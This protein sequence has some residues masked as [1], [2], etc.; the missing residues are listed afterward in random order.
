MSQDNPFP[1]TDLDRH[2]IWEIVVRRDTNFFLSGDWSLVEDD[3]LADGFI[4]IDAHASPDPDRWTIGFRSLADYR[5]AAI[6]GRLKPEDFA[7]DLRT[8]WLRCQSLSHIDIAGDLALAHK[9][10][11]GS[12]AL[13]RQPPMAFAWRSIFHLR[14]VQGSWKITGFTGYL[15]L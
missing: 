7:E 4:G 3:Y 5:D 12:I 15:P 1:T 8:A 9:R 2:A 6:A 11:Y 10:L 14:R 13:R